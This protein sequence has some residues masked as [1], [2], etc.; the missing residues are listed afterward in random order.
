[1]TT[2]PS[3][4]THPKISWGRLISIT[5]NEPSVT[6]VHLTSGVAAGLGLFFE[7]THTSM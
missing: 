4:S 7:T 5:V 3:G 2:F 1:M 6:A